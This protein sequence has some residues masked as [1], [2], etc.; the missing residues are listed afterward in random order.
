MNN[1]QYSSLERERGEIVASSLHI[2]LL[3]GAAKILKKHK[4]WGRICGY[5]DE[6]NDPSAKPMVPKE[7]KEKDCPTVGRSFQGD[8]GW[9]SGK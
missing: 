1:F 2:K 8:I 9:E 6:G 4:N 5:N 7:R 3:L